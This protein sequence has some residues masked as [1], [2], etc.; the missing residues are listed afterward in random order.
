M[1]EIDYQLSLIVID[2]LEKASLLSEDEAKQE[3]TELQKKYQPQVTL[4]TG[5]I[6]PSE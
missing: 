6:P 3:R 1:D 4:L 5:Y 2:Q